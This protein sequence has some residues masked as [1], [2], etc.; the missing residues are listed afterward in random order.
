ML[1][2]SSAIA[3]GQTANATAPFRIAKAAGAV[4]AGSLDADF[5]IAP[6]PA[7]KITGPDYFDAETFESIAIASCTVVM[8]CAGKMMVEFFSTEISAMVCRVRSCSATGC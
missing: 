2:T 1:L 8:N 6:K 3:N 7:L 5:S 4:A